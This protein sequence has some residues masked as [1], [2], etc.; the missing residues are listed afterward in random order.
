M[1]TINE[2]RAARDSSGNNEPDVRTMFAHCR[3]FSSGA[4]WAAA[5]IS[6]RAESLNR[7]IFSGQVEPHEALVLLAAYARRQQKLAESRNA[8]S[9]DAEVEADFQAE[10]DAAKSREV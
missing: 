8:F 1:T 5:R 7:S 2:F 9:P 4:D 10:V 6:D 3:G